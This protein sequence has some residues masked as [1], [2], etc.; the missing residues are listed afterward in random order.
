EA[1]A[2]EQLVRDAYDAALDAG[3]LWHEFGDS[4][5]LLP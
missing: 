4:C 1:V 5:L 2:G 3:Y